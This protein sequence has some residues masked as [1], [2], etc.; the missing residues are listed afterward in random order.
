MMRKASENHRSDVRENEC[1]ARRPHLK[2]SRQNGG[3]LEVSM[4]AADI[5]PRIEGDKLRTALASL[6]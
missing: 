2:I 3:A 4:Q 5:M 1:E 6:C